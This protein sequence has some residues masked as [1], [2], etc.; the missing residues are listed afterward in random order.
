MTLK[1]RL[2]ALLEWTDKEVERWID[3]L[4]AAE[5]DAAGAANDWGARDVLAHLAEWD[6][7][8]ADR[9]GNALAGRESPLLADD[10]T[11]NAEFFARNTARSWEEVAGKAATNRAALLAAMQALPD[12]LVERPAGPDGRSTQSIVLYGKSFHTA[13]HLSEGLIARGERAAAD[14]L[15][16]EWARR[17]TTLGDEPTLRGTITYNMACHYA[18][19]G[20]PRRALETLAEAVRLRPEMAEYATQ[21]PDFATLREDPAFR[22]LVD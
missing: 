8:E 11:V 20:Q 14:A 12:E 22:A 10:D 15:M 1:E 9:L 16:E 17:A 18:I 21:D 2:I 7:V 13:R 4:G 19:S 6:A 5:R 3:G